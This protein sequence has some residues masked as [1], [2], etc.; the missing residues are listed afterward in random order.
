VGKYTLIHFNNQDIFSDPHRNFYMERNIH[1]FCI[2][3]NCDLVR[4]WAK[5][6]AMIGSVIP[7]NSEIL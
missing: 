6:M 3:D 5:K 2:N 4:G 7:A 1:V